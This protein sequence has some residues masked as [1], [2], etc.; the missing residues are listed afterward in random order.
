[1]QKQG[2]KAA[3]HVEGNAIH[4]MQQ[5]DETNWHNSMEE[6][7][8]N[9]GMVTIKSFSFNSVRSIIIENQ[10]PTVDKKEQK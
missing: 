3:M 4:K 1:M 8:I 2:R 6:S 10:E 7:D 9:I 5:D